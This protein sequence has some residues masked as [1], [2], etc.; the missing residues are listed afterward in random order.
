MT[1]DGPHKPPNAAAP[2]SCIVARGWFCMYEWCSLVY[3]DGPGRCDYQWKVK[4]TQ[5]NSPHAYRSKCS[6]ARFIARGE[7]QL[8]WSHASTSVPVISLHMGTKMENNS[9]QAPGLS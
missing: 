7:S 5:V 3:V 2:Q 4:I 1:L 8:L 9:R 6:L